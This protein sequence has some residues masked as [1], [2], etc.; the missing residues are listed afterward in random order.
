MTGDRLASLLGSLDPDLQALVTGLAEALGGGA[1]GV[2][3][4][5]VS[6]GPL[7]EALAGPLGTDGNC[8]GVA[9][10]FIV[11]K[12]QGLDRSHLPQELAAIMDDVAGAMHDAVSS[13]QSATNFRATPAQL[14]E[15]LRSVG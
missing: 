3:A 15:R 6:L 11:A 13:P 2:E 14:L 12:N 8:R 1:G 7:L 5:Q 4:V 10:Y 9:L